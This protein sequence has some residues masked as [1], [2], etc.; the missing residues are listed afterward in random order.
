MPRYLLVGTFHESW[1]GYI[2]ISEPFGVFGLHEHER[3]MYELEPD[4]IEI[5]QFKERYDSLYRRNLNQNRAMF[6]EIDYKYWLSQ[7]N[8]ND[9][10]GVQGMINLMQNQGCISPNITSDNIENII[11]LEIQ[12]YLIDKNTSNLRNIFALIQTW[13]GMS[14]RIHSP[15]IYNNWELLYTESNYL[16]FVHLV[17]NRGYAESFNYLQS[18]EGGIIGLGPSFIAKH[19]CFWSGNGDRKNGLPILD[20]V[21]A[22]LIY[23]ANQAN[24]IDYGQF[25]SDFESFSQSKNMKPSEVEMALF[26]FS[27]YYW[28]T[29][30]TATMLFRPHID[31]NSKDYVHA[32]LIA[33]RYLSNN[34]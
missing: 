16:N 21:I 3:I 33:E 24:Q 30:N 1:E 4:A 5:N 11:Y 10:P 25:I 28:A 13:G 32:Y 17:L 34:N 29:Q 15:R 2:K 7:Y 19:I 22:K 8:W 18:D 12:K 6:P 14:A 23:A 20:N 9:N 26:A 31:H 27:R